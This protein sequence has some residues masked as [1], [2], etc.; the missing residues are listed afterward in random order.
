M[1]SRAL[2]ITMVSAVKDLD[3]EFNCSRVWLYFIKI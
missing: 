3:K 2:F 1:G